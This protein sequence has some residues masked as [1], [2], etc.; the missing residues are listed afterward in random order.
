V[1][2]VVDAQPMTTGPAMLT[3][4]GPAS[5]RLEFSSAGTAVVRI[6][7]SRLWEVSQGPA[8]LGSTVDGW[9]TVTARRPGPVLLRARLGW[10]L[11]VGRPACS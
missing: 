10:Q 6:R 2:R 7:T 8:C 9:L 1:W 11:L 5:F 4:L 3:Q